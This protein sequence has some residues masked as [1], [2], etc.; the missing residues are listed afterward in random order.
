[1]TDMLTPAML[2]GIDKLRR[3]M[4]E[5]AGGLGHREARFLVDAYYMLQGNRI[6]AANQVRALTES[7]EPHVILA[8]L[9]N[10]QKTLENEIKKSLDSYTNAHE[11]GLWA[12]S[13]TGIGPVISGRAVGAHRHRAGTDRRTHLAVRRT[14]PDGALGQ[15]REA[16]VERVAEGAVLEDR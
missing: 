16:P 11:I 7:E 2:E 4:R 9:F 14:R 10:Q 8:W 1:M 15:G 13:I 6:E 12:K 5:A 3:D